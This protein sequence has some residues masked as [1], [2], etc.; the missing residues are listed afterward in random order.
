MKAKYS[1]Y[2]IPK[3]Y[4]LDD[5]KETVN[6]IIRKYSKVSDLTSIYNWGGS[7]TPGISDLD[8]IFVFKDDKIPAIPLSKR[9]FYILNDKCRYIA[10]HPFFYIDEL[11]F[12]NIRHIYPDAE[13]A[14]IHGK[15]IKIKDSSRRDADFSRIA[16]VSDIIIR[17][18]PRDFL[19]QEIMKNINARDMLLRLNSLKYSIKTIELIT[20][21]KNKELA[22]KVEQIEELRKN[23]FDENNFNLLASLNEDAIRIGMNLAENFKNF[24]VA[25]NLVKVYS[26]DKIEYN[27]ARN[28]T[29]FIKN[30]SRE[31]AI[32]CMSELIKSQKRFF[33]ILPIEF[34]PQLIE[35]SKHKG[36][37]TNYIKERLS[38]NLKYELRYSYI[39]EKRAFILNKQAELASTIKHSNFV[40]FFDF[41]YRNR[42][43]INNIILNFAR[44]LRD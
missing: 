15:N 4:S 10:R 36:P 23:W 40:A 16:L 43:G 27:G 7:L 29:L 13:F 38:G 11:S 44:S 33:S 3:K 26:G 42:S 39:I 30:W 37:I 41:G 18:Y 32:R 14:L 28:T 20:K 25:N 2:N 6:F 1:F 34:A 31:K 12:Q 19:E 24:L 9:V 22:N 5:Y 21:E 35:Y 8:I 17:H